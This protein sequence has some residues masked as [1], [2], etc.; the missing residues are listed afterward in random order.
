MIQLPD[1]VTIK[2]ARNRLKRCG[3]RPY[4][5]RVTIDQ[6]PKF[7]GKRI[8]IS[9]ET[10]DLTQ[11]EKSSALALAM[12]KKGGFTLSDIKFSKPEDDF[13]SMALLDLINQLV[14]SWSGHSSETTHGDVA[15]LLSVLIKSAS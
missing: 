7:V 15:E 14:D 9:T 3:G 5:L 11:A 2:A 8:S 4:T 6:G 13:S 10:K 12:M 1:V